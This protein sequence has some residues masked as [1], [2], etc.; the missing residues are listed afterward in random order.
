LSEAD[1]PWD[2]ASALTVKAVALTYLGQLGEAHRIITTGM[3]LAEKNDSE[4]ARK[5]ENASW[6]SILQGAMVFLHFQAYEFKGIK[7]MANS[8]RPDACSPK[9]RLRNSI[10]LG[11][12]YFE[13]GEYEQALRY[14]EEVR[15]HS[16]NRSV[17]HWYWRLL[18]QL[19]LTETWLVLRDLAKANAQA[20]ILE[21]SISACGD[22]YLK[23]LTWETRAKL[24]LANGKQAEAEQY[25]LKGLETIAAVDVPL[26]AWRIHAAAWQVYRQ[27]NRAKA[28]M[29]RSLAQSIVRQIADSLGEVESLRQSFLAARDVRSILSE[30]QSKVKEHGWPR[31]RARFAAEPA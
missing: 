29:H 22:S 20:D 2:H 26:T 19:G 23:A 3:K 11:Y 21:Q 14:F 4:L 31:Q 25:I 12:A 28:K 9:L 24:A 6:L 18:A 7:E 17:L 1:E 5:D 15:D 10:L 13:E 27:T 16:N 8:Q 30:E